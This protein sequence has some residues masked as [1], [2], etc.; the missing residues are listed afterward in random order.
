MAARLPDGAI[1]SLATV[2]ASPKTVSAISNASTAVCSATSNGYSNGDIVV[3]SSGWSNLNNRVMRV[4]GAA[5]DAFNLEG[6][7]TTST[8]RFPAGS[9]SGTASKVTTF[10]QISQIM[11]INTSGGEQ[12]FTTYSFVEQDFEVQ[13]PTQR[14]PMTLTLDI[15]DDPSLA[16]YIALK[17]ASEARASR[18]LRA[19]WPD[20]SVTYYYGYV[21]FNE[22]PTVQKGAIM[23]VR[24]TFSLQSSPNRYAS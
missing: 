20:G 2:T 12:Q 15:A 9:G 19:A 16:G 10:T 22:T 24:A 14:S 11:G 4:A 1:I 6:L 5:T 17:A 3:M 8:T 13:T 23:Q 18:A 21:S 7:D